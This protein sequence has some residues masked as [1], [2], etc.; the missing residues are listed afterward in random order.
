MCGGVGRVGEDVEDAQEVKIGGKEQDPLAIPSSRSS[1][2][3]N[4]IL[5]TRYC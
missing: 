5:Y 3:L 1:P 4:N 2:L